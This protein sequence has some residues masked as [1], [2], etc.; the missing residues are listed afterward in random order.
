MTPPA[1][2]LANMQDIQLPPEV[3]AWP[4]TLGY[5]LILLVVICTII[6][7]TLYLKKKRKQHGARKAGLSLFEA[8]DPH[9]D[10][11]ATE[12]NQ[13]LKR[14]AMSYLPRNSIAALDGE[15]WGK[16]LDLRLPKQQQGQIGLLLIKRHQQAN[17]TQAEQQQLALL[18]NSWLKSRTPF[19]AIT[20][21]DSAC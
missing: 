8:L 6:A 16:W 11:F 19:P 5:W 20:S 2:P 1:S 4:I 21:E 9:S 12:V 3:H 15:P 14:V 18:A 17:L 10:N 7:I 13:L